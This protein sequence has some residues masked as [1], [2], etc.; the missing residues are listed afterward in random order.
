MRRKHAARR[1]HQLVG[2]RKAHHSIVSFY[3]LNN[4]LSK[5]RHERG[6]G[7]SS[8]S[9]VLSWGCGSG[10]DGHEYNKDKRERGWSEAVFLISRMCVSVVVTC[11][12]SVNSRYSVI[13]PSL[14]RR[15][16]IVPEV[17]SVITHRNADYAA[18]LRSVWRSIDVF[19]AAVTSKQE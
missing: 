19:S 6:S 11:S 14:P 5:P 18:A 15:Q 2:G 7:S 12:C 9:D 10:G 3:T 4:V 8:R 16:L 17:N 1:Q 13:D